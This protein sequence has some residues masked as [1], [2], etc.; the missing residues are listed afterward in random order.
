MRALYYSI[1]YRFLIFLCFYYTDFILS[2]SRSNPI[3]LSAPWQTANEHRLAIS[4]NNNAVAVWH[5]FDGDYERI[6]ASL[7]DGAAGSWSSINNVATVSPSNRNAEYPDVAMDSAGNTFAVWRWFGGTTWLIQAAHYDAITKS[8][9]KPINT[10]FLSPGS[11]DSDVPQV[12]ISDNGTAITVWQYY[13]SPWL[14]MANVYLGNSWSSIVDILSPSSQPWK[15]ASQPVIAMDPLGNGFAAWYQFD[16]DNWRILTR[17]YIQG[18]GWDMKFTTLS[19]AG[20]DSYNPQIAM[21]AQGNTIVVW[22]LADG[23]GTWSIQAACYQVGIGWSSVE[24][25]AT[26]VDVGASSRYP[27]V[28]IAM[29]RDGKAIVVW[30][31]YNSGTH[32][33][34]ATEYNGSWPNWTTPTTISEGVVPINTFDNPAPQISI[35][36]AGKSIAT[37]TTYDNDGKKRVQASLYNGTSWLNPA[38]VPV[39]SEAN[40]SAHGPQVVMDSSGNGLIVWQRFDGTNES[41][42]ANGI[43]RIQA[44]YY[45]VNP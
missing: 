17:P 32:Y 21:D 29:N 31:N 6:Q 27:S 35:D 5:R 42:Y 45:E 36:N 28:R 24:N 13:F 26:N 1:M 14:I 43:K 30:Y 34:Q 9:Q 16:S 20:F 19:S 40:Q 3:T 37:W 4:N 23:T 7:Y 18:I 38:S 2:F 8:W 44:T 33:V 15:D 39:I 22:Q 25:L 12:A 41:T 11:F 10:P